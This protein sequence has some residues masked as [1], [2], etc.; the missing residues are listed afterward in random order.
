[1]VRGAARGHVEAVRGCH[2]RMAAASAPAPDGR[3]AVVLPNS[4][5][6]SAVWGSHTWR[7][8]SPQEGRN[9]G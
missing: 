2:S 9:P 1:M 4:A 5:I 3:V 8:P 7:E 6:S